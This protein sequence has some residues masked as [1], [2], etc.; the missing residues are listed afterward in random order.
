MIQKMIFSFIIMTGL[1]CADVIVNQ[2]TKISYAKVLEVIDV[3]GYNYLRVDENGTERWVAITKAPVKAG[4]KIGYDTKTIM[5]DFKSK[6]LDK[7]FDE[8]VFANE[9]YFEQKNEKVFSL[10]EA[11]AVKTVKENEVEV[12]DSDFIEKPFYTVEELHKFRKHLARKKVA[13][14]AKVYKVSVDIM[15]KDWVHLGDGS[16]KESALTDDIVFTTAHAKLKAGDHVIAHGTI[17]IDKDFGFGYF[18]SVL[19]EDASFEIVD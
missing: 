15:K 6:Q 9:V 3:M 13:L 17:T 5:K 19:G 18:Y 11:I 4:D 16:G 12:M 8:I 1:I 10:K 7:T 2:P 14:K